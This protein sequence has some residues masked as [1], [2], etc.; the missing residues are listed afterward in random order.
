MDPSQLITRDPQVCGGQPVIRGTRVLLAT[1]LASLADGDTPDQ[2]LAD[3]PTLT[4]QHIDAVIAF[5]ASS[6][7]DD[8]PVPGVPSLK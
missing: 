8:L 1:V 6:A 7:R 3:F 5:A 4:R 2:I